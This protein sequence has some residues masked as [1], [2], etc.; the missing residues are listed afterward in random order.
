MKMTNNNAVG[1]YLVLYNMVCLFTCFVLIIEI[2]KYTTDRKLNVSDYHRYD[3]FYKTNQH[4]VKLFEGLQAAH[5]IHGLLGISKFRHH[6]FVNIMIA[7]WM[8]WGV[9]EIQ[10]THYIIFYWILIRIASRLIKHVYNIYINM[11]MRFQIVWLDY[12]RFTSFYL[13][14][15]LEVMCSYLVIYFLFS[16]IRLN[17]PKFFKI[18]S[19]DFV[20][21]Y[22]LLIFMYFTI[23]IPNL[24][25][26]FSYLHDKR[27]QLLQLYREKYIDD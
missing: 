23:S 5:I 18:E 19:I 22:T 15:P 20:V 1:F 13:M 26:T 21:D 7:N 2:F 25:N 6:T 9:I 17:G 4:S 12:F 16:D 14:L 10:N 8:V 27:I 24:F 3:E 11:G